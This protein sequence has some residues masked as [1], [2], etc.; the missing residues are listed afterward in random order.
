MREAAAEKEEIV[1]KTKTEGGERKNE[2]KYAHPKRDEEGNI[3]RKFDGGF[4][5]VSENLDIRSM[6]LTWMCVYSIQ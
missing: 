2:V 5:D 4:T 1:R 3:W 6:Q